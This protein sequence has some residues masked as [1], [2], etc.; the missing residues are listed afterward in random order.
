MQILTDQSLQQCNTMAVPCRAA[1]LVRVHDDDELEALLEALHHDWQGRPRLLLG[2]GS[3]VLLLD[4]FDGL[5]IQP[6]DTSIQLLEDDGNQLL[7]RIGAGH[8]WH[9]LVCWSVARGLYGLENLALIPGLTGA[10]PMQNIGAYGAEFSR[11]CVQVEV[12]NLACGER[13]K[14]DH[15]ECRFAYRDSIFKSDQARDWMITAVTIQ[16]YRKAQ[17]MLDYPGLRQELQTLA[18][19]ADDRPTPTVIAMAVANIRR[20]KLPDPAV[21]GNCGSFF[22]NPII[23]ETAAQ[24]L[25]AQHP[26]LPHWS[27][28]NTAP[29]QCK[30]S[31]AWLIEQCGWKGH[32]QGAAGVHAQHALVLVN[33][34]GASGK[35]IWQLACA[36]RDSVAEKFDL[37]LEPEPVIIPMQTITQHG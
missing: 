31:A 4:D 22:K 30:L 16:L 25:L 15:A 5:V 9:D 19:G 12:C 11:S 33:H 13:F 2:G 32:R 21:L 20:R 17:P 8:N 26:Q 14:L 29:R 27:L 36:I 23:T 37:V 7:C 3:N 35:A 18:Q 1:G 24:E 28:D 34:G 10:A 6:A